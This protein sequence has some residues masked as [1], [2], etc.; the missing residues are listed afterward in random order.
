MAPKSK[1]TS[2]TQKPKGGEEEREEPLQAVVF[3]DSYETRFAPFSLERPRVSYTR[4]TFNAKVLMSNS[5]SCHWQIL[6][7]L[8]THLSS[9][10]ASV[11][12]KSSCTVATTQIRW[13]SISSKDSDLLCQSIAN[14]VQLFKIHSRHFALLLGDHSRRRTFCGRCYTGPRSEAAHHR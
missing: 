4:Y 5:V 8:N 9:W 2:G 14:E 12:K 7:S 13:R 3:A 10:R 6:R 11:L 1:K